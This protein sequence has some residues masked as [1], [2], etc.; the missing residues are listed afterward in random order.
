MEY[1]S[2]FILSENIKPSSL[3]VQKI[4]DFPTSVTIEQVRGFLGLMSYYRKSIKIFSTL[5]VPLYDATTV[6]EKK[7]R[8]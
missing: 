3:K 2:L 7:A 1:L 6:K 5:A 8:Q 4:Q